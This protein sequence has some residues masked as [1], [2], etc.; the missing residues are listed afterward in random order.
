MISC[1]ISRLTKQPGV[2]PRPAIVSEIQLSPWALRGKA[3][4]SEETELFGNSFKWKGVGVGGGSAPL[5]APAPQLCRAACAPARRGLSP[6]VGSG[7]VS[8]LAPHLPRGRRVVMGTC[9]CPG[10]HHGVTELRYPSETLTQER[11]VPS[12]TPPL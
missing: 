12:F 5:P 9:S 3:S 1:R 8:G 6:E 2:L 7:L 11:S 4:P 10:L